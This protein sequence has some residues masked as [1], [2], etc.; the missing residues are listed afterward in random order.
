MKVCLE[1]TS[2]TFLNKLSNNM[3]SGTRR[4]HSSSDAENRPEESQRMDKIRSEQTQAMVPDPLGPP[5]RK[6]PVLVRSKTFDPS[7][8]SQIQTDRDS[9]TLRKKS[10][11]TQLSKTNSQYH[12][13]FKEISRE[14]LLRQSYT[15]A[16]QKDILYQGRLFVSDNWIC[17]HS[18]VFGK[19]IKIAIPV[20]SITN[21][22]KTK[23]AI[24]VPNALVI[25]TAN[26]RYMLV[27]LLSRDNTYKFLM[28]VCLHL[29]DKSPCN[30][31]IP[32]SAKSSFR[33][34]R[35]PCSPRFPL[36]FSG[37][38]IGLD[39]AVRQRRQAME[40]SSSSDSQTPDYDKMA[41][42]SVPPFLEVLKHADGPEE[43]KANAQHVSQPADAKPRE[44]RC[45]SEVMVNDR[46]LKPMSLNTLL[47]VYLFLV[48]LLVLSSCYMAF[49]IISLEQRLTTL[50]TMSD[51]NQQ[52]SEYLRRTTDSNT[53]LYSELT[54][55]LMKLE[56]VQRNLQRLLDE[57]G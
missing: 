11:Y 15:C 7:L 1:K 40:D 25:A 29:E 2:P 6:K 52:E 21:I 20:V 34:Q 16:L 33:G 39:G 46:T 56:K 12:K 53:E 8:L 28:S 36:S 49:K 30:S 37:D 55:N 57:A 31:P 44:T 47:C 14:E 38:L 41:A 19:D 22:K 50:G 3:N 23:T 35:T 45:G 9:K 5:G 4:T 17:F 42:F 27:S 54:V 24:L 51:F 13:L 32:S 18:N 26:D 10:P 48:C 43:P